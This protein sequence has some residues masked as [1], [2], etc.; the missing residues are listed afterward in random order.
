MKKIVWL[1]GLVLAQ[2]VPALVTSALAGSNITWKVTDSA[3][4]IQCSGVG[5]LSTAV[6]LKDPCGQ[7]SILNA[8]ASSAR[9]VAVDGG[10]D[11]LKLSSTKIRANAD[12]LNWHLIY[13]KDFDAGP[14]GSEWWY[15][16]TINGTLNNSDSSNAISVNAKMY[17]PL[18]TKNT[19][20]TLPV[21]ASDVQPFTDVDGPKVNP[22]LNNQARKII[23]DLTLTLKNT[24]WVDFSYAGAFIE[25]RAQNTAPDPCE[26]T[27]TCGVAQSPF[28]QEFLRSLNEAKEA[29]L[30][31]RF[32]DSSCAGIH[33]VK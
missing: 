24:H 8:S 15:K 16:T 1:S 33:M 11:Q 19:E 7:I 28:L 17:N 23:V 2:L 5:T 32:S 22:A 18:G 10:A 29:C 21:T 9:I 20:S 4:S 12:V 26:K 27:G 6:I 30:G 3:G 25:T 13:E 14:T 31:V